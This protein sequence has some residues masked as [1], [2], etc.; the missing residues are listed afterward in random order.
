MV[1]L[2]QVRAPQLMCS[3]DPNGLGPVYWP[4]T[5]CNV[6]ITFTNS[7][8]FVLER[9]FFASGLKEKAL[10]FKLPVEEDNWQWQA[11]V[12]EEQIEQLRRVRQEETTSLVQGLREE[13]V[14]WQELPFFTALV[15]FEPGFYLMTSSEFN[16]GV[17][18][19]DP[20]EIN[21]DGPAYDYDFLCS[22][23]VKIFVVTPCQNVK[24]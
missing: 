2:S 21:F 17:G 13:W 15:Q 20:A 7:N 12:E 5:N 4:K 22:P 14:A 8:Q 10:F 16:L 23:K 9:H 11:D 24:V 6:S 18:A 1:E 19:I 3:R